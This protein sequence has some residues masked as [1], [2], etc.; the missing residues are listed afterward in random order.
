MVVFVVQAEVGLMVT[1]LVMAGP[2]LRQQSFCAS[3]I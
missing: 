1:V 2:L 3:R